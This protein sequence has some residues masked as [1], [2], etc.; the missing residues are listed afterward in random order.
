M[1]ETQNFYSK[2]LK[3]F[4]KHTI[5][6]LQGEH[7]VP[8]RIKIFNKPSPQYSIQ[9][10]IKIAEFPSS[11]FP[12]KKLLNKFN[13]VI[14]IGEGGAGKSLS[15]QYLGLEGIENEYIPIYKEITES[16]VVNLS[17]DAL[18]R[19]AIET[20]TT[21]K[22]SHHKIPFQR[23][24][25]VKFLILLDSLDQVIHKIQPLD[26]YQFMNKLVKMENIVVIIAC[27]PER[28]RQ[29]KYFFPFQIQPFEKKE[30]DQ[31]IK[32]ILKSQSKIKEFK[33]QTQYTYKEFVTHPLFLKFC[34]HLFNHNKIIPQNK[35]SLFTGYMEY[36]S[37]IEDEKSTKP[38]FEKK[39]LLQ[40][41]AFKMKFEKETAYPYNKM[42][43]ILQ[44]AKQDFHPQSVL[45]EMLYNNYLMRIPSQN[46][47]TLIKFKHDT[48]TEFFAAQILLEIFEINISNLKLFVNHTNWRETCY[49]FIETLNLEGASKFIQFVADN[50]VKPALNHEF[51]INLINHCKSIHDEAIKYI[52]EKIINDKDCEVI[53]KSEIFIYDLLSHPWKN[54]NHLQ[55][56]LK[57]ILSNNMFKELHPK[58]CLE[59]ETLGVK[60][61]LESYLY[62]EDSFIHS[63]AFKCMVQLKKPLPQILKYV[64]RNFSS[65]YSS[66]IFLPNRFN[67]YKNDLVENFDKEKNFKLKFWTAWHLIHMSFKTEQMIV[68][69][70]K[71]LSKPSISRK[72]MFQTVSLLFKVKDKKFSQK[73]INKL[74]HHNSDYAK[75]RFVRS[76]AKNQSPKIKKE[77]L[78]LLKREDDL[79]S[80]IA[81][82]KSLGIVGKDGAI[83]TSKANTFLFSLYK[84]V[85]GHEVKK[86]ILYTL[87]FS[88]I[89][90][91]N[92]LQFLSECYKKEQNKNL[93]R[94][95]GMLLG[96]YKDV[97]KTIK[98]DTGFIMRCEAFEK[99]GEIGTE[100]DVE[101][102]SSFIEND[103][104][105]EYAIRA[106]IKI[107][108]DNVLEKVTTL[109]I[110]NG[111]PYGAKCEIAENLEKIVPL[112]KIPQLEEIISNIQDLEIKSHFKMELNNIKNKYQPP[113]SQNY[114]LK[115]TPEISIIKKESNTHENTHLTYTTEL[116]HKKPIPEGEI[117]KIKIILPGKG[118]IASY[119]GYENAGE[120]HESILQ[121]LNFLLQSEGG[122][123]HWTHG[124]L[125]FP[126]WTRESGENLN[127]RRRMETN[128]SKLRGLLT[129]KD[130]E[131]HEML[132]GQKILT[133]SVSTYW[134]LTMD[135][136]Y[137]DY[138]VPQALELVQQAKKCIAEGKDETALKLLDEAV[139]KKYE[140]CH[141]AYAVLFNWIDKQ[142]QKENYPSSIDKLKLYF[143]ARKKEY[144]RAIRKVQEEQEKRDYKEPWKNLA[145][146][147]ARMNKVQLDAEIILRTLSCWCDSKTIE[148]ET[149]KLYT[150]AIMIS[151]LRKASSRS[152][153]D[154]YWETLLMEPQI[155]K[156]ID[157]VSESIEAE[158]PHE[159]KKDIPLTIESLL[160]TLI[161]EESCFQSQETIE[162]SFINVNEIINVLNEKV[163]KETESFFS[164]KG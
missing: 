108:S 76:L 52:Y 116:S 15:L 49:F 77:L 84:E 12:I 33:K 27:R 99:I 64:K 39:E 142:N 147:M 50:I 146:W 83:L 38:Y 90:K 54:K 19:E 133:G 107:S 155:Q 14:L 53:S 124:F 160:C 56:I 123:L 29:Y 47:Q 93:K 25:H 57:L 42:L 134:Q 58:I 10:A 78:T 154:E 74:L 164:S 60:T 87:Y 138:Y 2:Y 115:F 119:K 68:F 37:E 5:K 23:T 31:Y 40:K 152:E 85:K 157:S 118:I 86:N 6:T 44:E 158:F 162:K 161:M 88:Q 100:R 9:Q 126:G 127:Y 59:L 137:F 21:I 131:N 159:E 104:L 73:Y 7:Y 72:L 69:L 139:E 122:I 153:K 13:Y 95:I 17:L 81:V 114:N 112:E 26:F 150:M 79:Y 18:I 55:N 3:N 62:D 65:D 143:N 109:S 132:S 98:N 67:H 34:L 75:L 144:E 97:V 102:L 105:V 20:Y 94:R 145:R 128:V 140:D 117:N 51:L 113:L 111:L 163:L 11:P 82:A 71:V 149:R 1:N 46:S 16:V 61:Q 148:E 24:K 30:Y 125:C 8:A 101:L 156:L 135:S 103:N 136:S 121:L 130:H 28:V 66:H 106:L 141:E 92:N 91:N 43:Q 35:T 63:D 4:Q 129:F 45:E 89:N 96:N 22:L 120:S 32:S 151:D 41:I 80:W 70:K 36:L 110:L 48:Y